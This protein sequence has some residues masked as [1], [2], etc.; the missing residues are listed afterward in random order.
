MASELSE[1]CREPVSRR[2]ESLATQ[3]AQILLLSLPFGLPYMPSLGLSLLKAGLAKR[4]IAADVCYLGLDFAQTIGY[5]FYQRLAH[6]GA[7]FPGDWIFYPALYGPPSA[8]QT[9]RFWQLTS[10]GQSALVSCDGVSRLA[11]LQ[12]QVAHAQEQAGMFIERCLTEIAWRQ[13]R[14]GRVYHHVSTESRLAGPGQADQRDP[15]AH[16]NPVWGAKRRR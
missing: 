9:E 16:T 1:Q 3:S 12:Q 8:A 6:G 5:T 15:S 14:M 11:T 7:G 2:A 10:A 4:G 13:Y